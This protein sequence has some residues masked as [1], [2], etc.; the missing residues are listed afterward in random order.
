MHELIDEQRRRCARAA[1]YEIAIGGFQ[2]F[3]SKKMIAEREDELPVFASIRIG[4]LGDFGR[5]NRTAWMA[6]Q[7]AMNCV[8]GAA[9]IGRRNEF[10]PC[11]IGFEKFVGHHEPAARV[12]I[13][14]VMPRREPEIFHTRTRLDVLS[15]AI[16]ITALSVTAGHLR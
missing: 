3:V 4:D 12:A 15:P 8:L 6:Q 13:E 1:A 9:G 10:R 16:Y 2:S 5:C 7:R 11:E 14:Q